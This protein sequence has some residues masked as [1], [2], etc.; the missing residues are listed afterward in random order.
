MNPYLHAGAAAL[1]I[2]GIVFVINALTSLHSTL[3]IPITMLGLFTLSAAVMGFLFFYKPLQLH[4]DN[5]RREALT[6]FFTTVGAFAL[7]VAFL[8]A[9]LFI[10]LV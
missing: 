1:Y 8:I 2:V 9:Y 7:L 4:F 3:Y 6:F 5:K 10:G